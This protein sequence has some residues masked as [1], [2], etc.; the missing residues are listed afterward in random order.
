[1]SGDLKLKASV[2]TDGVHHLPLGEIDLQVASVITPENNPEKKPAPPWGAIQLAWPLYVWVFIV[3]LLGAFAVLCTLIVRKSLL[4]RRFLA[5][6]KTHETALSPYDQF[7][8]DLR[9]LTRDVPSDQA[10]WTLTRS[11]TFFVELNQSFRW[12]LARVLEFPVMTSRP[13]QVA[14]AI[15]DF[16]KDLYKSMRRDL[17]LGLNEI[18][19]AISAKSAPSLADVQQLSDLCRGL[20]DRVQAAVASKS[21]KEKR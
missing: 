19:K 6:L 4:R 9:R 20:A 21:R 17:V 1:M 3:A 2:L 14:S 11:Q 8:K 16:D 13:S 18:G 5:E 7:N 12:Y 15:Q 10:Q